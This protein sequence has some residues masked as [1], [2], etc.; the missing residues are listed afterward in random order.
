MSI[1]LI[2]PQLKLRLHL[3]QLL[4]LLDL[5]IGHDGLYSQLPVDVDSR[6]GGVDC[7]PERDSGNGT[8]D[9]WE[10]AFDED[11]SCVNIS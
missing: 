8:T 7:G 6:S 2:P 3:Y 5:E 11:C 4:L 10:R 1:L 9:N